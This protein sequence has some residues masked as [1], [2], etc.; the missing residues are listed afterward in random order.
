MVSQDSLQSQCYLPSRYCIACGIHL[1]EVGTPNYLLILTLFTGLVIGASI[2]YVVGRYKLRKLIPHHHYEKHEAHIK[3]QMQ[4][5]GADLLL[6]ISPWI[7]IVGDLAPI[8]AGF[9]KI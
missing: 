3:V 5:Y 1:I 8:I 7:P 9:E 2:G 4:N 6:F